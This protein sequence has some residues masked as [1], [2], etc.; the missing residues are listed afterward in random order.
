V[1]LEKEEMCCG[2]EELKSGSKSGNKDGV[3]GG[4]EC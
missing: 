1:L 4:L 2:S 3:D